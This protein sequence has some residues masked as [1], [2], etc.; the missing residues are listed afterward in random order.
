LLKVGKSPVDTA[1]DPQELAAYSLLGRVLLNLD[2]V[3]TR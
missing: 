1:I 2:E 3:V